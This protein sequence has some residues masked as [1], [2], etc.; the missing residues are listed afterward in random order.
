MIRHLIVSPLTVLFQV[1]FEKGCFPKAFKRSLITPV[2][3]S[4]SRD[5]V[6]NYR[7]I[8]VLP[9]LSKI[10]EKMLNNRLI[11]YVNRYNILSGSQYGFRLG[12]STHDA[13][14]NL[15]E[16]V[17]VRLD[18][19]QR[20]LGVFLDLAKAFDTVSIP[21]L[22]NKLENIGI[23]GSALL[24]FKDFLVDRVQRVKITNYISSDANV[25]Y[26][27]PQG[28]IL[29]P[30]LFLIYI[31][32]LC[33]ITLANG[34]LFTY[35]D[36]TALIIYGETWNEVQS[37]AE[38]GLRVVADWLSDNLLTLNISKTTYTELI[39]KHAKPGKSR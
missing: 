26:G 7:P 14:G 4:G 27:V 16:Y 19:R 23:R 22:V 18:S 2:Y 31:N 36:D 11:Q 13:V 28:S 8:S 29:G 24:I 34:K 20:C 30:S 12:I 38:V 15:T 33:N 35:A 3:K 10:L 25:T 5:D 32:D 17:T 6:E 1:C 9:A 39:V 21:I 37:A